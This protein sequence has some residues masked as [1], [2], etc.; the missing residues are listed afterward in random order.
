MSDC[1]LFIT[2]IYGLLMAGSYLT[3]YAAP[4]PLLAPALRP[5]QPTGARFGTARITEHSIVN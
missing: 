4:P 5:R 1:V 3:P 2:I